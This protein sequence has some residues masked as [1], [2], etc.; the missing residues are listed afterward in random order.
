MHDHDITE[1]PNGKFSKTYSLSDIDY[2][3]AK[4][5]ERESIFANYTTF[6]NTLNPDVLAQ[7]VIVNH[8]LDSKSIKDAVLLPEA[9]EN[10]KRLI[11]DPVFGINL[12]KEYNEVLEGFLK[13]GADY[14]RR[15][16]YLSL[17]L[18]AKNIEDAHRQFLSLESSVRPKINALSASSSIKTLSNNDKINILAKF[19]RDDGAFIPREFEDWE[20]DE[21]IE[22]SHIAPSSIKFE[23]GHII[24][25]ERRFGRVLYLRDIPIDLNDTIIDGICNTNLELSITVNIKPIDISKAKRVLQ[26]K[27]M[28][29][30]EKMLKRQQKLL[31]KRA[32]LG[33][34]NDILPKPFKEGRKAIEE[35]D[36]LINEQ[37]Q[38]LFSFN[39]L[40]FVKADSLEE[41]NQKEDLI[42]SALSAHLC[43]YSVLNYAQNLG[44]ESVLPIGFGNIPIKRTLHSEGLALF[45]PFDMRH[46]IEKDGF[47]YSLHSTTRQPIVIN[48]DKLSSPSGF[49]LG[50]SG[51]GKGFTMK[52]LVAYILMSTDDDIIIIDPENEN[53]RFI[54]ALGGQGIELSATSPHRVNPFDIPLDDE[55]FSE[56]NI[57]ANELKVELMLSIIGF[58]SGGVDT[59]IIRSLVDRILKNIYKKFQRSRDSEDIPTFEDFYNELAKLDGEVEEYLRRSM[60]IFVTGSWNLFSRKT[61]IETDNRLICYNTSILGENLKPIASFIMFDAIWN[62]IAKNRNTTKRTWVFVDEAHLVFK[63]PQEI[64]RMEAMYKRIRKYGGRIYSITQNTTDLLRWPEA[65]NMLEN[66][67]FIVVLNQKKKD[68]ELIESLL[69]IP[70]VISE[71]IANAGK[72]EGLIFSGGSFTPFANLFPNNTRLY[73]LMTTDSR[74]LA[75]I[76]EKEKLQMQKNK[77]AFGS[78]FIP[79]G[80]LKSQKIEMQ[81]GGEPIG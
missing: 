68:R 40:I 5:E 80:Q 19:Y 11:I 6:L 48:N 17:T 63:N 29:F 52:P 18:M 20:M 42:K 25:E 23:S 59:E 60:E 39:L 31:H 46:Q 43:E 77:E 15:D 64:S 67:D 24:F 73:E 62:R 79:L 45:M 69:S 78:E 56:K 66:S 70:E 22:K 3:T 27:M 61:N 54:R 10:N 12:N 75:V 55:D 81:A 7:I 35:L 41:L 8:A 72:G 58:M 38:K 71:N 44:L 57:P 74:E 21:G 76:L 47:F 33:D 1:L 34:I 13:V 37:K 4:D 49:I 30:Q 65:Q 14:C 32:Y 28:R 9:D 51:S 16:K 53:E 50:S 26:D 36:E 2:I